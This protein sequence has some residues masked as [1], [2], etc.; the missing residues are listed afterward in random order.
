MK[1]IKERRDTAISLQTNELYFLAGV[2]GS[3]RL[4]GIEDPFIGCLGEEIA[5]EWE[6]VKNSLL[7]KGYL[8]QEPGKLELSI[9]PEV[10]DRVAIAGFSERAC[11][12]RY[13]AGDETFEGYLHITNQ[14]VV[15][16]E[17]KPD[18]DSLY[19][20]KEMGN[21]EQAAEALVERMNWRGDSPSNLPAL[22]LTRSQFNYLYEASSELDVD[23]LSFRFTQ[24]TGDL[25][26]SY[27]MARCLKHRL[28]EGELHLSIWNEDGWGSQG[29]AFLVGPSMNW[30]IRMSIRDEEDWLVATPATKQQFQQMLLLWFEGRP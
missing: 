9:A 13:E 10:F 4:L 25:E 1:T 7:E 23:E 24:A 16:V 29:A 20:L 6:V 21:V 12:A 8:R 19:C 30:L 15:Q 18:A 5:I 11:W 27:A 28:S 14:K 2:L 3:D 22:L 26:S 17:R